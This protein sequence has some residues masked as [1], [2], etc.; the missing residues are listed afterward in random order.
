MVSCAAAV[1]AAALAPAGAFAVEAPTISTVAGTGAS[2]VSGDG[3]PA[4]DAALMFPLDVAV[5]A[6]GSVLIADSNS[7]RLRRVSPA[8][9]ISTVAGTGA[10]GYSGDGGPATSAQLSYPSSVAVAPDGSIVFVDAFNRCVRRVG[11]DGIITTIAGTGTMG[12]SPDG[13]AATAANITPF[14]VAV[15]RDGSVLIA[16]SAKVRRVDASGIITTVAGTGAYASGGD[17]GPATS[18]QLNMPSAVAVAP[19]GGILIAEMFGQRVRRVSPEG[20]ISTIAGTGAM[21]FSGDGGP[22]TAAQLQGP[23]GVAVAPDGSVL[24]GDRVNHRVRRVDPQ[25]I[26][27]TIAG[28]GS[29]EG[30]G[31]GGPAT[32]AALYYPT[33]VE[34]TPA[35]KVLI[36][37]ARNF[38][39][40]M[41]EAGLFTPVLAVPGTGSVVSAPNV[42]ARQARLAVTLLS[43]RVVIRRGERLQLRVR[44]NSRARVR[45]TLSRGRHSVAKLSRSVNVDGATLRWSPRSKRRPLAVGRY[46]I[47][48]W[49]V[50]EKGEVATTTGT[51]T[52]K[53]AAR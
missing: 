5:E 12:S 35:G 26:I 4:T 49:A 15:E 23:E 37:D 32:N 24:I 25:G 1:G 7:T 2:G 39:V 28:G 46:R 41:V 16:E 33:G 19:D 40:R 31:D 11:P 20:I 18:A 48:I 34:A 14:A 3:G 6:D 52:V 45:V 43:R 29:P 38:R 22:A 9:V 50:G 17:G 10:S 8:G 42:D 21:G 53:R 47:G 30:V 27:T 13:G 36:A 51:L 44:T